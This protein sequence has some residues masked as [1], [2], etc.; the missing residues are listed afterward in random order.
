[1]DSLKAEFVLLFQPTPKLGYF[2]CK[3][4]FLE[5]FGATFHKHPRLEPLVACISSCLLVFLT[6]WLVG[7]YNIYIYM[8]TDAFAVARLYL[9]GWLHPPSH[10]AE[11]SGTAPLKTTRRKGLK[12]GFNSCGDSLGR[13]FAIRERSS[14]NCHHLSSS[15]TLLGSEFN[16]LALVIKII[17]LSWSALTLIISCKDWGGTMAGKSTRLL[18][19]KHDP[20]SFDVISHDHPWSVV[21]VGCCYIYVYTCDILHIHMYIYEIYV[22]SYT[23]LIVLTFGWFFGV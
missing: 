18:S 23:Y 20:P 17:N 22:L 16:S 15:L 8:H 21:S 14:H 4:K 12:R 9:H 3:F 13:M 19:M 1:M 10:N 5:W 6:S 2:E 11:D 7:D